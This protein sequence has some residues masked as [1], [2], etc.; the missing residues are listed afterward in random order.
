MICNA[1]AGGYRFSIHRSVAWW[2]ARDDAGQVWRAG[3]R[4]ARQAR[5]DV[6]CSL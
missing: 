4:R 6:S 5:A 2:R 3:A 1:D